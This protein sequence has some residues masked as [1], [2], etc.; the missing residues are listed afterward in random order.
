MALSPAT[1]TDGE[2]AAGATR[3]RTQPAKSTN[4]LDNVKVKFRAVNLNKGGDS[5]AN[6][7]LAFVVENAI[8]V[9][10]LTSTRTARSWMAS[11]I[12]PSENDNTFTFGM[13]LKL[14]CPGTPQAAS[15]KKK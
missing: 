2:G 8:Q 7:N 4:E 15:A 3:R 11:W 14:R 9:Q 10:P 5:S 13:I 1:P 12:K 6:S